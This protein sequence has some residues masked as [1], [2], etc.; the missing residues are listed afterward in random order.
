MIRPSS[1]GLMRIY[2][3]NE[4]LDY[5]RSNPLN[6]QA[7]WHTVMLLTG[8]DA[9]STLIQQYSAVTVHGLCVYLSSLE[10]PNIGV[11]GRFR[12]RVVPGQIERHEK[13]YDYISEKPNPWFS[14]RMEG[15][16]KID[17]NEMTSVIATLGARPLL[18][19]A[20]EETLHDKV[21][22]TKLLVI[23]EKNAQIHWNFL[24]RPFLD[25][26]AQIQYQESCFLSG[27]AQLSKRMRAALCGIQCKKTHRSTV[28]NPVWTIEGAVEPWSGRCSVIDLPWWTDDPGMDKRLPS[29]PQP[30]EWIVS[31]LD[32]SKNITLR[33]FCGSPTLLYCI[34]DRLGTDSSPPTFL[35]KAD[36][37]LV[38]KYLEVKMFGTRSDVQNLCIMSPIGG[39]EVQ[40]L[41]F[42][43]RSDRIWIETGLFSE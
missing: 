41:D 21:L 11:E 16:R 38:C 33:V 43:L 25:R 5:V 37:C 13:Y 8:F 24:Y 7:F 28:T 4:S 6:N 23:P 12:L 31:V 19:L 10:H 3:K 26:E 9:G 22:N 27:P 15:P 39:G 2:S 20:I 30:D 18:Q 29:I 1:N 17:V 42:Q 36:D 14:S 40:K 35:L 32:L 34:L